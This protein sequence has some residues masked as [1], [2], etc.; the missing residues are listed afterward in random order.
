MSARLP[1]RPFGNRKRLGIARRR[2]RQTQHEDR[3]RRGARFQF[4]AAAHL[5]GKAARNRKAEPGAARLRLRF[6]FGDREFVEDRVAMLSRNAR[7]RVDDREFKT[8]IDARDAQADAALHRIFDRIA[9][10]I[11]EH[12]AQPR[13]IAD[14][15]R[16]KRRARSNSRFRV[17]CFALAARAARRRF[18][19]GR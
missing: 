1:A 10:E 8:T 12:L 6:L 15:A 18:R 19:R 2:K 7:P 3:A 17:L 14:D 5:F 9:D 11:D 13:G 4:D 16:R